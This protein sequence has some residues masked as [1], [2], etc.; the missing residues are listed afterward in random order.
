MQKC[1]RRSYREAI[2]A[3]LGSA[4]ADAF[5]IEQF[6]DTVLRTLEETGRKP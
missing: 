5:R 3:F 1:D 2:D 4:F 6:T